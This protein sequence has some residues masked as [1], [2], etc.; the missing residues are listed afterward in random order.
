M[1]LTSPVEHDIFDSICIALHKTSEIAEEINEMGLQMRSMRSARSLERRINSWDSL[2][3]DADNL[4]SLLLD[5]LLLT[6]ASSGILHHAVFLFDSILLCCQNVGGSSDGKFY[7]TSYPIANWE[8]GPAMSGLLSMDVLFSVPVRLLQSIC[9]V[10]KGVLSQSSWVQRWVLMRADEGTF[11]INWEAHGTLRTH[12]FT[13]LFDTQCDQWC[14]TLQ[15]LMPIA[16]RNPRLDIVSPVESFDD[17][18]PCESRAKHFWSA[19]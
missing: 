6:D 15:A 5:D 2:G 14:S 13:A 17:T 10:S 3:L 8:F 16:P 12:A 11:E 19:R 18:E 1:E 9:R 4:G 7:S